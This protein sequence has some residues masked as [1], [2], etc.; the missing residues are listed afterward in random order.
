M[1]EKMTKAQAASD[2]CYHERLQQAPICPYL[3]HHDID[4]PTGYTGIILDLEAW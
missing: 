2:P 4:G 3:R 1:L